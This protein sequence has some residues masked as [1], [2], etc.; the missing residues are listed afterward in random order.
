MCERRIPIA[1]NS[2]N[3]RVRSKMDSAIVL[4][5]PRMPITTDSP[6]RTYNMVSAM[7]I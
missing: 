6:S 3:S 7:L 4:M 5:M 1:R 2:P